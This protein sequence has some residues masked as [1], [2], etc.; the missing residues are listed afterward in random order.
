MLPKS[1]SYTDRF[2]LAK[3]VRVRADGVPDDARPE[4]GGGDQEGIGRRR[5]ADPLR[6]EHGALEVSAVVAPIPR[7]WPRA[8]K[9][10]ETSLRNAHLWGAQTVLLV[11]A[12][13][14]PTDQ[15]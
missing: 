7:S 5:L 11:P 3:E 9:G 1:M 2:K 10:M 13:V 4:R 8:V 14:N 12:V 6:D 15:L